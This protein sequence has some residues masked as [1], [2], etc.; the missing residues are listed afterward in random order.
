MSVEASYRYSRPTY[1][2]E[3]H[4]SQPD[5]LNGSV[6]GLF[7]DPKKK[8]VNSEKN[9]HLKLFMYKNFYLFFFYDEINLQQNEI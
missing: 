2:V 7:N 9:L 4:K 3:R 6:F 5:L 1:G 8:P